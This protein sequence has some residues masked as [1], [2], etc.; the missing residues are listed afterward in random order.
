MDVTTSWAL[1]QY[2]RNRILTGSWFVNK[3]IRVQTVAG[4]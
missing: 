3:G 1:A 2:Y 4:V